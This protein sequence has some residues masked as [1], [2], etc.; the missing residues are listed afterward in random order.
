[1][2]NVRWVAQT[3]GSWWPLEGFD[4]SKITAVG[5]YIIWCEGNPPFSEA[6]SFG[7]TLPRSSNLSP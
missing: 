4:F 1:M 7:T 3:D 2:L 6:Q 5:V